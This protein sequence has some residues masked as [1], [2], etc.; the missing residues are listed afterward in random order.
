MVRTLAL[1]SPGAQHTYRFRPARDHYL[2]VTRVLS[3]TNSRL[4]GVEL[5][6]SKKKADYV[7]V[8]IGGN[9]SNGMV[10]RTRSS[11]FTTG[12]PYVNVNDKK[13][14]Y[15]VGK[16]HEDVEWTN[17]CNSSLGATLL[18]G[19]SVLRNTSCKAEH[20]PSF[21]TV[22]A[23]NPVERVEHDMSATRFEKMGE[24]ILV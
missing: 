19:E 9:S 12:H 1:A 21:A 22:E 2:F 8:V 3:V 23:H 24:W 16:T 20:I 18:R 11:P 13:L 5:L 4:N 6:K 14:D 15:S 10:L 7:V 17:C